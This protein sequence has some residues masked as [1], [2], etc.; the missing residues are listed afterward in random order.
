M[1]CF[2]WLNGRRD[3]RTQYKRE[4]EYKYSSQTASLENREQN[5]QQA[6]RWFDDDWSY[7]ERGGLLSVYEW[8][9][10]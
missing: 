8:S 10:G 7:D 4:R 9:A 6:G 2:I 3:D 1:V 5:F